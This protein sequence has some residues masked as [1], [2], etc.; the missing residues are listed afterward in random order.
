MTPDEALEAGWRSTEASQ[1]MTNAISAVRCKTRVSPASAVRRRRV[2]EVVVG[3]LSDF[4]LTGLYVVN[5]I[6]SPDFRHLRR[7][8]GGALVGEESGSGAYAPELYG[9]IRADVIAL[10]LATVIFASKRPAL[11]VYSP[12]RHL[13]VPRVFVRRHRS[14]H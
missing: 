10:I 13:S 3:V 8:G 9:R 7:D 12:R 4:R 11:D 1:Q 5:R 6:L 14:G 2:I